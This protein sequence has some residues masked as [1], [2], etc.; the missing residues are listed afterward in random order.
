ML[1]NAFPVLSLRSFGIHFFI[2]APLIS[3]CLAAVALPAQVDIKENLDL[4]SLLM[5]VLVKG[6]ITFDSRNP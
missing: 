4:D 1:E 5:S 3:R 6:M 2:V